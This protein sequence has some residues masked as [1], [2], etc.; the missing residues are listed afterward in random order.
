LSAGDQAAAS[1][2]AGTLCTSRKATTTFMAMRVMP[3]AE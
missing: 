2:L 3:A 1:G